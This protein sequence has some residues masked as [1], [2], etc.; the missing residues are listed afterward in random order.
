MQKA[1]YATEKIFTFAYIE[2]QRGRNR[3]IEKERKI[4]RKRKI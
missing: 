4:Q 1:A 3:E 2:R